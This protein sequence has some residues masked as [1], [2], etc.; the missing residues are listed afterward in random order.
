MVKKIAISDY[1]H[2]VGKSRTAVV[3]MIDRGLLSTGF[4]E[5][6]GKR[7]RAV[8]IDNED[9]LRVNT[10]ETSFETGFDTEVKHV[11]PGVDPYVIPV[12]EAD[13]QEAVFTKITPALEIK[14]NTSLYE[15]LNDMY[16]QNTKLVD[17]VKHLAELAGQTK[18]LTDS[19]HRT[20]EQY[21]ELIH[22]KANLQAKNEL[23]EKQI[24]DLKKETQEA[25]HLKAELK[26]LKEKLKVQEEVKQNSL[27]SF[28]KK[29]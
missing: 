14:D 1:A 9:L 26:L 22:E 12:K 13:T 25:T 20:K 16:N 7:V 6:D 11:T 10:F 17:D 19:E 28:I 15:L 4:V 8:I 27:A 21:F 29:L 23:L 5:K 24:E 18:L 2:I 3:K